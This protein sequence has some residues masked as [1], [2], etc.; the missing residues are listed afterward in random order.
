MHVCLSAYKPECQSLC[1]SVCNMLI[2]YL[3]QF[4]EAT[5]WIQQFIIRRQKKRK[6][7][8]AI[9]STILMHHFETHCIKSEYRTPI[10]SGYQW[11]MRSLVTGHTATRILECIGMCLITYTMF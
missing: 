2:Q 6:R 3:F 8:A 5:N 1:S 10:E 9:A 7:F 11:V 4:Q